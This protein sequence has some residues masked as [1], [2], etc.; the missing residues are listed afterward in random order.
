MGDIAD[1]QVQL[2]KIKRVRVAVHGV[3]RR[4][5]VQGFVRM[6]D[7]SSSVLEPTK[8]KKTTELSNDSLLV[9]QCSLLKC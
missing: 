3:S 1:Q 7:C 5:F 2:W 8:R 4:S 9:L 6:F